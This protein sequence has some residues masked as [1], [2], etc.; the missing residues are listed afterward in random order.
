MKKSLEKLITAF[1]IIAILVLSLFII[2]NKPTQTSSEVAKCIRQNSI[3][4]TQTGCS[5]CKDQEDLFGN[6]TQYLNIVDCIQSDNMQKCIDAKIEG[7]PTW[8]IKN[9]SYVG[10]QTIEKLK[11]LTGC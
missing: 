7:T 11:E 6:N 5:H 3:L 9:Q 8:I 10:V 2:L 4:Y 1:V